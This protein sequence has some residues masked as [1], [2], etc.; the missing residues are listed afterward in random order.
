MG[1]VSS[2]VIASISKPATDEIIYLENLQVRYLPK[3]A[4]VMALSYCFK[5]VSSSTTGL[6]AAFASSALFSK[7]AFSMPRSA[8]S[9]FKV[10]FSF[11]MAAK[12]LANSTL[13]LEVSTCWV[14]IFSWRSAVWASFLLSSAYKRKTYYQVAVKFGSPKHITSYTL[15][16]WGL[17]PICLIIRNFLT[18]P[19]HN[20]SIILDTWG[21]MYIF[22]K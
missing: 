14:L 2:C 22:S 13:A 16:T 15:G 7:A 1:N 4:E 10:S 21:L 6:R 17:M 19:K 9:F 20:T 11:S 8:Y 12:A 3:T 5:L 18:S